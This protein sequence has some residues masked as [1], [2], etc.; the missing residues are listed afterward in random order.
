ML[1]TV[2][3]IAFRKELVFCGIYKSGSYLTGNTVSP[4]KRPVA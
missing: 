2:E 1:F 4:I 3:D